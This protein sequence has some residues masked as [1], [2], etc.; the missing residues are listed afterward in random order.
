MTIL[1]WAC[2]S[3]ERRKVLRHSY[4]SA[5]R[6]WCQTQGLDPATLATSDILAAG[7]AA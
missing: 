4:L 2:D 5:V 6:R 7:A 1:T 3:E